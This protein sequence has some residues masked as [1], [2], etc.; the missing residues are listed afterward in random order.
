MFR[1]TLIESQVRSLS[2]TQGALISA[3]AHAALI[4]GAVTATQRRADD[5]PRPP[6]ALVRFLV[7]PDRVKSR[8]VHQEAL[9]WITVGV[10]GAAGTATQNAAENPDALVKVA[11]HGPEKTAD[12]GD[13]EQAVVPEIKTPDLSNVMTVLQVDSAVYRDPHSAAPP[14]PPDMLK[15]RVQGSAS[16]QFVV[17]TLGNAVM[18]TF[19]VLDATHPSFA[20]SVRETLPLMRFHPAIMQSKKVPQLVQQ[21]FSFKIQDAAPVEPVANKKP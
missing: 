21:M 2:V 11:G 5:T 4:G 8:E 3:V 17:D 12:P 16:V 13:A 10:G 15:A 19:K 18:S 9:Q 1:L 20:Q 6:N 7:P 14:Y